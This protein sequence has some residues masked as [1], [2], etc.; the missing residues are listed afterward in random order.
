MLEGDNGNGRVTLALLGQ[1]LDQVI[2]AQNEIKTAL[3]KQGGRIGILENGAATK[4]EQIRQLAGD[5]DNLKA[6]DAWG[7]GI[8]G[9]LSA[10]AMILGISK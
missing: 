8:T 7:T 1:K 4:V 6:R 9:A 10:I 5:V 3:E 2:Q